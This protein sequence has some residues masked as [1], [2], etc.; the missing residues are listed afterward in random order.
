MENN[1]YF[2]KK[3]MDI[4]VFGGK[5]QLGQAIKQIADNYVYTFNFSDADTVDLCHP[6]LLE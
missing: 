5:G 1:T 4:L 3:K 6:D 2:C